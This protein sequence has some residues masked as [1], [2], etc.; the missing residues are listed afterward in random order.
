M[1]RLKELFNKYSLF[2][3]LLFLLKLI[4]TSILG[5]GLLQGRIT[6]QDDGLGIA[7]YL[8]TL[9]AI[10]FLLRLESKNIQR[11]LHFTGSH[12]LKLLGLIYSKK[13]ID[14]VFKPVIADAQDRYN[15]AKDNGHTWQC[16]WIIVELA[17]DLTITILNHAGGKVVDKILGI[18][19]SL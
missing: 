2:L 3:R 9:F 16:R 13:N 5:M 14:R 10:I 8:T 4:T 7:V 15:Q 17:K 18:M 11:S 6:L 19:K 12:A 1:S